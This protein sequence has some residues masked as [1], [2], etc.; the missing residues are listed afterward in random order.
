VQQLTA[1]DLTSMTPRADRRGPPA[2]PAPDAAHRPGAPS[3]PRDGQLTQEHL[4]L[5][6]P[7]QIVQAHAAGR[8]ANLLGVSQT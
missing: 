7:E 3:H 2:G 5:M 1:D 8:L 6:T 4:A